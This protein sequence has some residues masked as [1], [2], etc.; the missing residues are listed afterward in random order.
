MK[1]V[2]TTEKTSQFL[3]PQQTIPKILNTEQGLCGMN[4]FALATVLLW[5]HGFVWQVFFPHTRLSY[6]CHT[7]LAYYLLVLVS[8]KSTF[9][10]KQFNYMYCVFD[11]YFNAFY[12]KLWTPWTIL[13]SISTSGNNS[14]VTVYLCIYFIR[15][16]AFGILITRSCW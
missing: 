8:G 4:A 12:T 7:I 9:V 2:T 10:N 13:K 16:H 5:R 11:V 3:V 6:Y 14:T 15:L 1:I